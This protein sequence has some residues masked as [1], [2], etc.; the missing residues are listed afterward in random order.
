MEHCKRHVTHVAL[1][2]LHHF[3]V[4]AQGFRKLSRPHRVILFKATDELRVPKTLSE[5][6][7]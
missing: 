6:M 2:A 7:P 1:S 4:D 5:L 3:H